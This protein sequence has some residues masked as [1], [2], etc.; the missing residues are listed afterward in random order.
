MAAQ[1]WPKCGLSAA[2]MWPEYEILWPV[3]NPWTFPVAGA[4]PEP[5]PQARNPARTMKKVARPSP[6]FDPQS[7]HCTSPSIILLC[8]CFYFLQLPSFIR[9][10]NFEHVN[11]WLLPPSRVYHD[12]VQVSEYYKPQKPRY[13]VK[14]SDAIQVCWT[15]KFHQN[16]ISNCKNN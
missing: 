3:I 15:V 11:K 9:Y 8:L 10:S 4:R 5:K 2:Q 16:W 6:T 12:Q 14:K 13:T 1:M 7:W